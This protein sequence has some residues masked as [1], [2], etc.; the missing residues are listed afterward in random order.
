MKRV[1]AVIALLLV[2]V[3]VAAAVV[4]V[5]VRQPF[6]GYPGL[7][8]FVEIA[9]GTGS[10]S[11]GDRLVSAGVIRDSLT[12]RVALWLTGRS[13]TL[14]AGEYRFDQPMTP[15]EVIAKIAR[16]DVYVIAVTFPEGLTI[17]EM[18]AIFE[19]SGLGDAASFAS[20]AQDGSAIRALDSLARTLE[21]YLFPETYLVSRH[22][23]A[24][25]L[26]KLMVERFAHV[27]TPA[28]REAAKSQGLSIHDVA[29]LA[30]IVE[31]ET[32]QPGERPLVAR[33]YLNRLR[34]GM[35][36][37][38][39]PTVI[40]AL[41]LAGR[42]RGNL[43]RDDLAVD[44]RYNTYRFP[45]LPPGP[46]AAPGKASIEAVIQPADADYLYFVSRNDGTH[47]FARTL[48]EHNRNVQIFQLRR[49]R[50]RPI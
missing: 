37:Q 10:R 39:D 42:Y 50:R 15:L 48:D 36:L 22:T 27:I 14:K 3:A 49:V 31:K 1:A 6:R 47:A 29:T 46:I 38:C 25:A 12:Y 17:P 13:K 33:V 24:P 11:I 9:P 8:Q 2:A 28:M 26:V 4:S 20:A 19:S 21:G 35:A 7:E 40:Y 34:I 45:G 5:R 18:A 23:D 32:A 41:A 16:G 43:R 30:S 44:S